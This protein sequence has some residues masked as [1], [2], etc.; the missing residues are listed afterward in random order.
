MKKAYLVYLL[1]V[2][3]YYAYPQQPANA[4]KNTPLKT[5]LTD[6]EKRFEV[7]ISYNSN[8]VQGKIISLQKLPETL[9]ETIEIISQQTNLI[10]RKI[11]AASYILK[12]QKKSN[13]AARTIDLEEVVI[14]NYLTT[15]FLK[16]ID[17]AIEARPKDFQVLPGFVEADVM[18]SVQLIPG[19]QS[20]DET[21]TGLNI[22]G[23][24][25]D[26]NLILWDGIKMYQYDHFFGMISSFNPYLIDN[27]TIYKNATPS[28]YGNHISGVIDIE[29]KTNIPKKTVVG[30]GAN[31]IYVDAFVQQPI[32]EKV[33]V[34]ASFR[35]SY[36]DAFETVTFDEFSEQIF[37]N[38]KITDN[39]GTFSD[40]LS[41]TNNS[42][43]FIDFTAKVIAELTENNTLEVSAI[44]SQNDLDFVSQFDEI[45]RRTE[46][47][48]NIN[49]FG[50]GISWEYLWNKNVATE[51]N[52]TTSQYNFKYLGEELLSNL[53]DYETVKE[54]GISEIGLHAQATYTLNKQHR[55]IGGYELIANKLDYTIGRQ[56]DVIFD[57]DF[58]V[59]SE[60]SKNTIHAIFG[61]HRFTWNDW[62]I[63]S[64]IR[65]SYATEID[66][67]FVEPRIHI[68]KKIDDHFNAVFSAE[69]QYQ[70][71]S[72]ITEFE[73]QSFGLENQVWVSTDEEIPVLR[74]E[75]VSLGGS[76]QYDSWNVDAEMYY[77]K[78]NNLTSLTRGFDIE[79][80]GL[81]V[82]ESTIFGLDVLV[83]KRFYNFTSLVSYAF[84]QN[85]FQFED[86][87]NTLPF[88]GNFD[89][90]HYLSL[91]Q[92]ATF[93][94][95]ELSLGWRYRTSRPYTL[96]TGLEG[97]TAENITIQYGERNGERLQ[98]YHRLDFSAKYKLTPFKNKNLKASFGV[99]LLNIYNQRNIL[100][101]NYRVILNTQNA[102][103]QLRT[104]DKIS[105]GRTPNFMVRLEF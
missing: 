5:V 50:I 73:T 12:Q 104:I 100:N 81:S 20:P 41:R 6:V 9:S 29:S 87:N 95:L 52:L 66:E 44:A 24:T 19:I 16:T 15:G 65:G 23:G 88:D 91:V 82:G 49:N 36:S 101:R 69:R 70:F 93:G 13:I 76:F 54:N 33:A 35:R 62:T 67:F 60:N 72:Q 39:T 34:I 37:Q 10:F 83:K 51:L 96:A 7:S 61:E 105:L 58:L 27:V 17:G 45:N 26:Q 85:E 56:S 98:P 22:R 59:T 74:S 14:A 48:L 21:S 38:T 92:S 8:I 89:I 4:Y 55:F 84:T 43:Y 53:F 75:Q 46:D 78:I 1:L 28:R 31:M 68:S 25:P 90:R 32:G 103:F 71:V 30:L 47:R 63:F 3:F 18:Q 57:P 42:F 86:L 79:T 64:G 2:C 77:K 40:M 97:D 11:T 102:E 94:N 80:T 99:S